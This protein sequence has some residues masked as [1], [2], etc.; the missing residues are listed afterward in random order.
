MSDEKKPMTPA[1]IV[2]LVVT[3]AAS[4]GSLAWGVPYYIDRQVDK[5]I[6]IE[7]KKDPHPVSLADFATVQTKVANT[8][9]IV[10][11]MEAAMIARDAV[12]LK[13][14]QDRAAEAADDN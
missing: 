9:A 7:L 3:A 2:G 10:I 14:F 8:E 12:I 6:E 5:Q 4:I 11:R 1:K 13:Y